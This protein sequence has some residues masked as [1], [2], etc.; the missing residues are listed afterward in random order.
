M[1]MLIVNL[2]YIC[3]RIGYYRSTYTFW[4]LMAYGFTSGITV[5]FYRILSAKGS[6]L[7]AKGLTS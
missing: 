2:I 1:G 3:V 4:H 5:V 7:S 6:D